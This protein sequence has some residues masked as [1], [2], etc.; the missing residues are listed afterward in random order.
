MFF[1]LF[2]STEKLRKS[3][4]TFYIENFK[5]KKSLLSDAKVKLITAQLSWNLAA[6]QSSFPLVGHVEIP[7]PFLK[8][9]LSSFQVL[10]QMLLSC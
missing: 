3:F 6:Y 4:S 7:E 9:P 10:A 1:F 5:G 8:E 2:P